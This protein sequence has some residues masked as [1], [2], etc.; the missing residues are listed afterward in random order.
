MSSPRKNVVLDAVATAGRNLSDATI[1]ELIRDPKRPETLNLLTWRGRVIATG[2]QARH[3]GQRYVPISLNPTVLKAVQFPTRVAPRESTEKLFSDTQE[4]IPK[5]LDQPQPCT[6]S[7]VFCVF[8]SWLLN[9][10]PMVPLMWINYSP[11]SPWRVAMELLSLLCKRSLVLMGVGRAE[12][13]A[14]PMA[15]NP[16]LILHEPDM[17]SAMQRILIGSTH[18]GANLSGGGKIVDLFGAK[19][20]LSQSVPTETGVDD[21][22]FKITLLPVARNLPRLNSNHSRRIGEEFQSRFLAYRLRN[23]NKVETPNFDLGDLA[24]SLQEVARSM[25]SSVVGYADSQKRIVPVLQ[26]QDEVLRVERSRAIEFVAIEAL[27]DFCHE[28]GRSCV[29]SKELGK[30]IETIFAGRGCLQEC[31]PER[32]GWLMKRMGLQPETIDARSNGLKLTSQIRKQV[33]YLAARY[34]VPLPAKQLVQCTN[35]DELRTRS[36]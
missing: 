29:R 30:K 26:E 36:A 31:S 2:A 15:I 27:R 33:H 3:C 13:R 25:A 4:L 18:R 11:G 5:H 1:L 22:I 12:I 6:D 16:T 20:V 19:I 23:L 7:L 14:L 35:C 17:R 9:A 28:P 32:A 21:A 34:R 24:P 10:L 8:C